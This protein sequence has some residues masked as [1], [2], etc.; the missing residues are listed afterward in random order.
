ME[1]DNKPD[2]PPEENPLEKQMQELLTRVGYIENVLREQ[3]SRLYEVERRLGITPAKFKPQS[4]TPP[5]PRPLPKQ[6]LTPA[7]PPERLRPETPVSPKA[8]QP[9]TRPPQP[10]PWR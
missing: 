5:P 6:P 1:D 8:T 3:L 2:S 9:E 7:A 10:P 4:T